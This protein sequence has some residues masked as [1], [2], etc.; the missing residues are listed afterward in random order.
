MAAT[1]EKDTTVDAVGACNAGE[2]CI[3]YSAVLDFMACVAD[4]I[5]AIFGVQ[6]TEEGTPCLH[7]LRIMQA[8]LGIVAPRPA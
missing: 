1:A 3:N 4:Y 8:R 5:S 6:E 2:G 7:C